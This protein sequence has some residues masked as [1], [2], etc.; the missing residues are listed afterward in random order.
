[1]IKSILLYFI[2][3][4]LVILMITYN[5]S[6]EIYLTSMGNINNSKVKEVKEIIK[7]HYQDYN[8]TILPGIDVISDAKVKGL[9]RYHSNILFNNLEIIFSDKAGK[10]IVLTEVDICADV[11]GYGNNWGVFGFSTLFGKFSVVSTYR[12]KRNVNDLIKKSVIHELGHSFGL[13]HCNAEDKCLMNSKPRDNESKGNKS[14]IYHVNDYFCETCTTKLKYFSNFS[15]RE[16][17]N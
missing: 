2:L 9:N 17:M 7:A 3:I 15:R 10:V 11:E 8:V 6:K 1:M 14:A 13:P 16:F 12:M 5:P 4:L